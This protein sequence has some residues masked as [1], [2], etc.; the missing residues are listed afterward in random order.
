MS[1]EERTE[2]IRQIEELAGKLGAEAD[3]VNRGDAEEHEFHIHV[4][5]A[6][7]I[8]EILRDKPFVLSYWLG[9]CVSSM[10]YDPTS[11]T[12][13]SVREDLDNYFDTEER[14]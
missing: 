9:F 14:E 8:A 12:F 6:E 1:P 7:A 11:D 5:L 10:G 13:K 4:G 2:T 3:L